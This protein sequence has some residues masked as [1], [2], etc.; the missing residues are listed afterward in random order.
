MKLKPKPFS[1]RSKM[2]TVCLI[3]FGK[4]LFLFTCVLSDHIQPAAFGSHSS[5]LKLPT[6]S[7]DGSKWTPLVQS[8]SL[9][10]ESLISKLISFTSSSISSPKSSPDLPLR[11]IKRENQLLINNEL[12]NGLSSH[13]S[14]TF[15]PNGESCFLFL[16]R[17]TSAP[18]FCCEFHGDHC[19]LKTHKARVPIIWKRKIY[20]LIERHS[21]IKFDAENV[22][23]VCRTFLRSKRTLIEKPMGL[24][25]F[26]NEFCLLFKRGGGCVD[27]IVYT[28]WKLHRPM[29]C[30]Y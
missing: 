18:E 10:A 21:S 1:I 15:Q 9:S 22:H 5:P 28:D 12:A 25:P 4:L 8:N 6:R 24:P 16:L 17:G 19:L 26:V 14:N 11:R 7:L 29:H 13:D 23:G 20:I 27:Y 3:I 30:V 2:M